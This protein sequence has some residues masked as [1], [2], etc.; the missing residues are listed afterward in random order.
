[1]PP[2]FH[3]SPGCR[4]VL[5]SQDITEYAERLTLLLAFIRVARPGSA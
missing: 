2:R 4:T 1:M 5:T 3:L